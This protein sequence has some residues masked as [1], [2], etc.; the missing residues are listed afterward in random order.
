LTSPKIFFEHQRA[1]SL[2]KPQLRLNYQ[3]QI[4]I[5]IHQAN[6]KHLVRYEV[7]T[8]HVRP[9]SGYLNFLPALYQESDFV[10]RF[11]ALFE[12]TF[13]P[14]VQTLDTLWAYLDPLTAP[15]AFLPFLSQWVAWQPNP[16]WNLKLQ[17]RLIRNA[18]T[19]YR[20]HGTRHGIRFYLHLYTGL[21]LDEHLPESEKHI[22]IEEVFSRGFV[23]GETLIGQDSMLGGGQPYH[24]IIQLRPEPTLQIDRPKVI[25]IIEQYKPAFCT[26]ELLGC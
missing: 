21:P 14:A 4:Q 10:R 13:D 9:S 20:W 15:E 12:Q 11:I 8:L 7:F 1:L 17:R 23:F 25:E 16:Q 2:E 19:L 5:Y 26:Y 18:I 24:F 22:G 6:S 3:A